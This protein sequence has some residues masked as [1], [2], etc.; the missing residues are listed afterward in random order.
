MHMVGLNI[1]SADGITNRHDKET[2]LGICEDDLCAEL[3]K[4]NRNIEK[5]RSRKSFLCNGNCEMSFL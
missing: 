4:T 2:S 5:K 3:D 1:I